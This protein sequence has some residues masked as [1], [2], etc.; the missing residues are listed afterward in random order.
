MNSEEYDRMYAQENSY[1]WFVGRHHLVLTF[2]R[3]VYSN[4]KDLLVLD[5]GCGTGAMSQKLAEFGYVVS[6]DFSPH[7]LQYSKRRDLSRLCAADAMRLPFADKSIDVIVALDILEHLPDDNAAL[8]EFQRV[9]KPGGRV[10]AT[11]PAYT[12]LWSGHDVAL[13]HF[14]RYLKGEVRSRFETAKLKIEKLSYAMTFLFPI[15][16]IVRRILALKKDREPKASI[17]NAPGPL[18]GMLIALLKSENALIKRLNLPF[19]V[20]VFCMAQRADS[21]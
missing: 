15:V 11:V 14:R 21:P 5:I 20:T 10:V 18:N 13:M 3:S 8:R 7:A 1:W 19:G 17:V 6:A 9:L 16:W 2:L 12:S 4:R